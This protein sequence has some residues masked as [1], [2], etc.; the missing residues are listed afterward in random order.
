MSSAHLET[1][2]AMKLSTT[3]IICQHDALGKEVGAGGL[4]AAQTIA[5]IYWFLYVLA[6]MYRLFV[7]CFGYT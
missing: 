3:P 4:Q 2:L 7:Y 6:R 1:V 5:Q